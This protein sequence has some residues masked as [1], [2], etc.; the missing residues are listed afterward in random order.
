MI[1]E[2]RH[3]S[4]VIRADP[5]RVHAY[6]GDPRNLPVW[7]TGLGDRI[8]LVDGRWVAAAAPMGPVTV[9]FARPNDWGVLDHDVVLPSGR[10]VHNPVRVL[11]HDEGAEIVFTVRRDQGVTDPAFEADVAA[12]AAD[13]DR[14]RR[15]IEG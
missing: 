7:A 15:V 10:T 6:A 4:V 11:D 14:L 12:V 9:T 13:L 5:A 3:V 8:E 1:Q 2:S